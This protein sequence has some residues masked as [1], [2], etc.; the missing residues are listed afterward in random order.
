MRSATDKYLEF[1]CKVFV[2]RI[3]N[4]VSTLQLFAIFAKLSFRMAD[5]RLV[6]EIILSSKYGTVCWL[7]STERY[8]MNLFFFLLDTIFSIYL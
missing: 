8:L 6:Q 1:L 3:F 5:F 2:F 7:F 4:F